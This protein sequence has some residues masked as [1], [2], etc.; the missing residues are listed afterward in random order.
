MNDNDLSFNQILDNLPDNIFWPIME[1]I[2]ETPS[3]E[4]KELDN[5]INELL[6][7]ASAKISAEDGL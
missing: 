6:Q 2:E 1:G 5:L 4:D 3:I 7:D